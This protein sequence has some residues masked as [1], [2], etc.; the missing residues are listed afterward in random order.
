MI[1][2]NIQE[3]LEIFQSGSYSDALS[4]FTLVGNRWWERQCVSCPPGPLREK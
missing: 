4:G 1:T 2:S 3:Q